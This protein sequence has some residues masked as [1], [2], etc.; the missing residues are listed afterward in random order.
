[1]DIRILA[2][3]EPRGFL[4]GRPDGTILDKIQQTPEL[5]SYTQTLAAHLIGLE[6]DRQI[7]C[8]PL[9]VEGESV[10]VIDRSGDCIS[11]WR[12]GRWR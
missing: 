8:D 9:R 3:E 11:M 5:P 4:A 12:E 2:R 1:M 6:N 10:F 7:S